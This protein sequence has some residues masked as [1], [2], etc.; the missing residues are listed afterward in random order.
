MKQPT[1]MT[2]PWPDLY[3]YT[4]VCV[5]VCVCVDV[6]VCVCVYECIDETTHTDDRAMARPI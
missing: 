6:D 3:K 4:C 2:E 1:Q 5:C